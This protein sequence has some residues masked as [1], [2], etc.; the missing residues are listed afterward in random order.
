MRGAFCR[1]TC[2]TNGCCRWGQMIPSEFGIHT[3][4][5][6]NICLRRLRVPIFQYDGRKIIIARYQGV[7][8]VD[9][10]TRDTP[11]SLI[12]SPRAVFI[13]P[14]CRFSAV[15]SPRRREAPGQR[16]DEV[17]VV[18]HGVMRLLQQD[19]NLPHF[20]KAFCL[21]IDPRRFLSA[22]RYVRRR[23]RVSPEPF[24]QS[25]NTVL[26]T[27]GNLSSASSSVI[28]QAIESMY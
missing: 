15:H 1:S 11:L 27:T 18:G 7:D 10:E 2:A 9:C 13:F 22:R 6:S 19:T 25:V 23:H 20:H 24:R 21:L 4:A 26:P 16:Q 14:H 3:T 5:S 17:Y 8:M 12:P 28:N